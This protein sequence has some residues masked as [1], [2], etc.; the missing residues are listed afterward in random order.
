M[1][2]KRPSTVTCTLATVLLVALCC[3]PLAGCSIVR[4][5]DSVTVDFGGA[6]EGAEQAIDDA[7]ESVDAALEEAMATISTDLQGSLD[8]VK[9][10]LSR[11]TEIE[12]SDAQSGEVVATVTDEAAITDLLGALG[13]ASWRTVATN[14]PAADAQYTLRCLQSSVGILDSGTLHEVLSFTTYEGGFIELGVLNVGSIVFEVPQA[15]VD[16]LNALVEEG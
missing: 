6:L 2:A 11:T 16:A 4:D 13:Y 10:A 14:P 1:K 8:T 5:G 3:I 7:R 12:V 9:S 15:D